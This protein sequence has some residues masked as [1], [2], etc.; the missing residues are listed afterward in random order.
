[1][2][3]TLFSAS[4]GRREEAAKLYRQLLGRRDLAASDRAIVQNNLAMQLVSPDTA[5]EAKQLIEQALA[6]QGPHPSLLDTQGLALL[7]G[8][9]SQEAVTV[10]RE[11]AL[12]KSAEKSLHLAL[13]LVATGDTDEARQVFVAARERGLDRGRLDADDRKR[14]ADVEAALDLPAAPLP[15]G[16]R[17]V[18]SGGG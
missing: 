12:D 6:E 2:K 17:R 15:G 18:R 14:L 16:R 9:A 5:A 3:R 8:G 11:A 4:Q 10:L 7:A 13:A 1:V